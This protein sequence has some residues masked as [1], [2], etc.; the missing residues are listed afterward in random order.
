MRGFL[1]TEKKAD[2]W[3]SVTDRSQIRM[4]LACLSV[5]II[6]G[7]GVT[8]VHLHLGIPGHKAWF[9]IPPIMAARFITR[10]RIGAT[11]GALSM[12]CTTWGL[13][14]HLAGGLIGMPFIAF[15]AMVWDAIIVHLEKPPIR[16]FVVL[17]SMVGLAVMGNAFAFG[18]RLLVPSGMQAIHLWGF[19]GPWFSFVSYLIC[20]LI[21]GIGTAVIVYLAFRRSA[22]SQ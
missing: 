2:L 19:S 8:H 15:V 10:C 21:A 14:G 7:L 3:S 18:K 17:P 11:A 16:W 13:G 6:A 20:G 4:L 22:A 9:W 5:G 1:L 12:L